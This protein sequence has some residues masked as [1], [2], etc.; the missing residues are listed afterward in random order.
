MRRHTHKRACAQA[1]PLAAVPS[2]GPSS[3]CVPA[4]F[5]VPFFL[6]WTKKLSPFFCAESVCRQ[7]RKGRGG[8][9]HVS[10][11]AARGRRRARM[12][13]SREKTHALSSKCEQRSARNAA[14][15][16]NHARRSLFSSSPSSPRSS[17][18]SRSL[19]FSL[20]LPLAISLALEE[21]SRIL[22]RNARR[23]RRSGA[24]CLAHTFRGTR[25]A[26]A[27]VLR[28][29]FRCGARPRRPSRAKEPR[30]ERPY[31]SREKV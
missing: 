5:R 31:Q 21:R 29:V 20:S 16:H 22:G 19:S 24:R 26:C 18:S 30:C 11:G 14:L 13:M 25:A 7:T 2:L 6:Q 15:L 12:E 3:A 4:S 10:G 1:R 17:T 28:V 27:A 9:T 23:K 8:A